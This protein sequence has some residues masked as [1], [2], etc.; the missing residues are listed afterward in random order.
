MVFGFGLAINVAPLTSTVL[1]AVPAE[2]AG[3]ASAVNNDVA[4]AASL[5]AVAVLP[6]AAGLTGTSYLHPA[7][8]TVG[9]H[10]ASL[11]AAG[12]C[13]IGGVLAAVTIRNPRPSAAEAAPASCPLHCGLDGPPARVTL[14]ASPASRPEAPG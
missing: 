11:I 10:R 9:F 13:V 6:A 14:A 8:F 12:L 4:R 7:E 1:A 2:H 5:I 3:I